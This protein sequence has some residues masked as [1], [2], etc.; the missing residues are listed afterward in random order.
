MY[1]PKDGAHVPE[2]LWILPV[3]ELQ[4]RTKDGIFIHRYTLNDDDNNYWY[5]GCFK[6]DD[7]D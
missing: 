6:D 5:A 2:I 1:G 3:V 7:E 4:E